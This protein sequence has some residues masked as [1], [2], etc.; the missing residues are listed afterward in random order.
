MSTEK[1]PS[2]KITKPS[3]PRTVKATL[4]VDAVLH[5]KWS[6]AASLRGMSRHAFAVAALNEAV[7]GIVIIDRSQAGRQAAGQLDS[8]GEVDRE[9]AA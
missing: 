9:D 5:T 8:S 6:A 3:K 4:T 1:T 2:R 7:R